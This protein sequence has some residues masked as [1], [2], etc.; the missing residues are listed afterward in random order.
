LFFTIKKKR[1]PPLLIIFQRTWQLRL[2]WRLR[3]KY[4]AG[5]LRRIPQADTAWLNAAFF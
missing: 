4:V 3:Q 1:A 5:W 2:F